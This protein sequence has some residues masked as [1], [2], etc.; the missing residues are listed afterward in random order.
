M[1]HGKV[2]AFFGVPPRMVESAAK[3]R[4]GT[5]SNRRPPA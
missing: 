1:E 3:W 2:R 5:G 4:P